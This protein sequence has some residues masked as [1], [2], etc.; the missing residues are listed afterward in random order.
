[1]CL[2]LFLGEHGQHEQQEELGQCEA[3]GQG[4]SV[5]GKSNDL[6]CT[7]VEHTY[8]QCHSATYGSI[9]CE[10]TCDDVGLLLA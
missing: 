2:T 1:M 6:Q 5:E 10:V 7:S 9:V 4:A 3:P 8:V